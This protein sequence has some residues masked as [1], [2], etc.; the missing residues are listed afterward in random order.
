MK[1]KKE[2]GTCKG[3][4]NKSHEF[5]AP[6]TFEKSKLEGGE[7]MSKPAP[8]GAGGQTIQETGQEFFVMNNL[9]IKITEHFPTNGKQ[10][11]ELITEL[12]THKAREKVI[13]I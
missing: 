9:K 13:E 10:I 2:A 5:G 7:D 1:A 12:I 3:D 8:G 4:P 6:N 11:D